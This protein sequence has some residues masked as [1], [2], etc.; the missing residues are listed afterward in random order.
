MYILN[1]LRNTV[2]ILFLGSKSH[3]TKFPY[4]QKK[5]IKI[6]YPNTGKLT[7]KNFDNSSVA[8]NESW[9]IEQH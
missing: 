5:K 1:K 6:G 9:F 7:L 8:M 4:S 3:N 2:I